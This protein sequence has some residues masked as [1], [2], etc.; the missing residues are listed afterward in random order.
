[1]NEWTLPGT[2]VASTGGGAS[3]VSIFHLV[4][5]FA[6]LASRVFQALLLTPIIGLVEFQRQIFLKK[7]ATHS[8][9]PA[10]LKLARCRRRTVRQVVLV[11]GRITYFSQNGIKLHVIDVMSKITSLQTVELFSLLVAILLK[12]LSYTDSLEF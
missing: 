10:D 1:M 2:L 6:F 9:V 12:E 8:V 4:F 7:E 5:I 3:V 11:R